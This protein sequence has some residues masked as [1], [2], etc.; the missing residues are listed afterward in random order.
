MADGH[1]LDGAGHAT[2]LPQVVNL[3]VLRQPRVARQKVGL[4]RRDGEALGRLCADAVR[5]ATSQIVEADV[6]AADAGERGVAGWG[7]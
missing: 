1:V 3:N 4:V 6:L 7:G 2:E 5:Q